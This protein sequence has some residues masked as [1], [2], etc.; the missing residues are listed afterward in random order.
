[1]IKVAELLLFVFVLIYM[2]FFSEFCF[3]RTFV[4]FVCLQFVPARSC[5]QLPA[6][7]GNEVNETAEH[8]RY[9][10]CAVEKKVLKCSAELRETAELGYKSLWFCSSDSL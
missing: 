2:S 4:N 9:G 8:E 6:A 7:A 10:K 5:K 1:M 3:L